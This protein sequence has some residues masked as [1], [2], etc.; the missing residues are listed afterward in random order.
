MARQVLDLPCSA[1][2]LLVVACGIEF[3]DQG[4]NPC[5][6]HWEYGVSPAGPPGKSV[7]ENF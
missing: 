5:P 4:L 7:M 2:D 1:Q 6:L 3:P